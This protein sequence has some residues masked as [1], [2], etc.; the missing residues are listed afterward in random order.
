MNTIT[1]DFNIHSTTLMEHNAI[2][3]L[4]PISKLN[5]K[6]QLAE[7]DFEAHGI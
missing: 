7:T 3:E 4:C 6:I 2:T 1:T 5:S